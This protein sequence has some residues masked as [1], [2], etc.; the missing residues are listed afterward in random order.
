VSSHSMDLPVHG[1]LR[2][3]RPRATIC[4]SAV[5]R[6]E[7]RTR[8]SS[9]TS[10]SDRTLNR[11]HCKP[12]VSDKSGPEKG[13][14]LPASAATSSAGLLSPV[15]LCARELP[16]NGIWRRTRSARR[17]RPSDLLPKWTIGKR[18]RYVRFVP[19]A[20]QQTAPLFDRL[21]RARADLLCPDHAQIS[22]N[23]KWHAKYRP[24]KVTALACRD[25]RARDR[26]PCGDR[27]SV[28]RPCQPSSRYGVGA[29][30][31]CEEAAPRVVDPPADAAKRGDHSQNDDGQQHRIFDKGGAVLVPA[32]PANK[33][34][35]F[36]HDALA[37]T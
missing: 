26:F 11:R 19:I 5:S 14:R 7:G 37:L 1:W 21:V 18:S 24:L 30:Q 36:L 12:C 20:S 35:N 9:N 2:P 23:V 15:R 34:H 16:N 3:A 10:S 29:D 31:R 17:P 32:Q 22:T 25:R 6:L 33:F 27:A 28:K 13:R 4:W 8:A